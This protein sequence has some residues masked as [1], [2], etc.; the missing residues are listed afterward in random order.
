MSFEGTNSSGA[1]L[2]PA[3]GF[4]GWTGSKFAL[5]LLGGALAF[6]GSCAVAV[7]STM[8]PAVQPAWRPISHIG[9]GTARAVVMKANHFRPKTD[10]GRRLL[11]LRAAAIAKGM[12]L[13]PVGSI[14]SDLE[15]LRG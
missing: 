7:E 14:I 10:L 2:R 13:V 11:A 3:S 4:T 12:P 5:P 8:H 6:A 9:A 1:E 15:E